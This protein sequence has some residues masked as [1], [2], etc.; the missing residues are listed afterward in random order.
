MF[1][2]EIVE[3]TDPV[4]VVRLQRH[5]PAIRHL[6]SSGFVITRIAETGDEPPGRLGAAFNSLD[7]PNIN[8]LGDVI[9]KGGYT[10]VSSGNEGV[11]RFRSGVLERLIDDGFNFTPSGQGGASSYTGFAQPV[12][13]ARGEVGFQG[14]FSF[15]DGNQGLYLF[16]GSQVELMFDNNP[17]VAVPGQ[18]ASSEWTSFPFSAGVISYL[19]DSGHSATIAR[20][21]DAGFIEHEGVYIASAGSG[22]VMVADESSP[23]PGQGES[24]SFITFDFFGVMNDIGDLV[25]S[26][27]YLGGAGS[28]GL[29][30]YVNST[31]DLFRIA[32][33]SISPPSQSALSRFTSF[34]IFPSMNNTGQ[35]AF[36]ANY[37]G[38][39]GTRGIFMGDGMGP[40]SVIVDNTGAFTVPGHPTSN[41]TVFGPPVMNSDGDLAFVAEFGLGS[42]DVGLFL[43]SGSSIQLIFDLSTPVPGQ[44]LASFT[45]IGNVALNADGH[46][47]VAIRYSGGVG[48]EGI[49]FWDGGVLARVTDES[50]DL[51]GRLPTN[52]DMMLGIGGSG[53]QDGKASTLNDADEIVFSATFADGS[54]GIY[55]AV[56]TTTDCGVDTGIQTVLIGDPGNDPDSNGYGSVPAAFRMGVNELSNTEYVR[57]LN[58]IGADDINRVYDEVMTTSLRGGILRFGSPGD[59]SYEVKPGFENMPASGF[60]WTDGARLCNWLHNGMPSGFQTPETTEDGAYDLSLPLEDIVRN[61][62]A[63]WFIPTRD[64]WYKAAYYDPF[65]ADA[66]AGGTPDYWS[67][68]TRSD[69]PPDQAHSNSMGVVINPGPNVA[70]YE[71]GVDW[72]ETDCSQSGATCGNVSALGSAGSTS[73]WGCFDMGGNINEWTETIGRTIAGDPPLP[74]RLANGGD[75]ANPLALLS[76]NL[77]IDLNMQ[78]NAANIGMRV[79]SL[80]CDETSPKG[81]NG[82]DLAEEFGV[83]DFFDVS[84]FMSAFSASDPDA[85]LNNDGVFNFFDVSSFLGAFG[86]GCP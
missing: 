46:L 35:V 81:C 67:Y 69:A 27:Q 5:R 70:N 32:D 42:D 68:P 78:V 6:L 23:V 41:F 4:P 19:S 86:A 51:F 52:F 40:N 62:G 48:N 45:Q 84:A 24:A 53:G 38:G 16:D 9:F 36:G 49:Y 10:G 33:E 50:Q 17:F 82:A 1:Q 8:A 15:G 73:P 65:N 31:G 12:T 11:Y 61:P 7:G 18:P 72:N 25:L 22:A 44:P 20:Y 34:D 83:L 28:R 37:T 3:R 71:R 77:D 2:N 75:F 58:A 14:G 80:S 64:E 56:P 39:N 29:Y 60:S 26:A 30:R 85:D 13:N 66:D 79:A 74:T 59:Y 63:R 76:S 47:A 21:R 55:R 43:V 57:F 54:R